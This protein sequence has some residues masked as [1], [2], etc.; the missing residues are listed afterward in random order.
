MSIFK[1]DKFRKVVEL[2]ELSEREIKKI[3]PYLDY[4]IFEIHGP[5]DKRHVAWSRV[6]GKSKRVSYWYRLFSDTSVVSV[7]VWKA[8][9][10]DRFEVVN[11]HPSQSFIDK[12][13][14]LF[15]SIL[16]KEGEVE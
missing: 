6:G 3:T 5:L 10:G 13:K 9:S 12:V 4:T 15:G 16:G 14:C 1:G 2:N 8:R 11:T 7:G